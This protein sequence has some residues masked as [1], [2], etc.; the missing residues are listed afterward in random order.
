[1]FK[2]VLNLVLFSNGVYFWFNF[3]S[4]FGCLSSY[5]NDNYRLRLVNCIFSCCLLSSY[6]PYM[7]LIAAPFFPFR[8]QLLKPSSNRV[9]QLEEGQ[10]PSSI[11]SQKKVIMQ[12]GLRHLADFDKY[13]ALEMVLELK[14]IAEQVNDTIT[15]QCT[16]RC[17]SGSQGQMS[18]SNLTSCPC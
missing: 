4:K 2:F 3:V 18:T 7:S 9:K 6:V 1:M 15:E 12:Y 17:K 14:N 5:F 11:P 10:K 8:I 16:L 13:K